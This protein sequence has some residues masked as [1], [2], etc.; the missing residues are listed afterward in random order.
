MAKQVRAQAAK[1]NLRGEPNETARFLFT[2]AS[3]R[4]DLWW[5]R[6]VRGLNG[7]EASLP[8]S[9]TAQ[10]LRAGADSY[11]GDLRRKAAD[12]HCSY[13][14]LG[15]SGFGAHDLAAATELNG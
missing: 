6:W 14:A 3:S 8:A 4:A 1:L 9:P 2:C 10:R 7:I 13:G 15:R 5:L 11:T 12:R